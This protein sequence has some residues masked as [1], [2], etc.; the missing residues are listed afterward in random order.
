VDFD[1][2]VVQTLPPESVRERPRAELSIGATKRAVMVA[3][4]M[5]LLRTT[6]ARH[7]R[8]HPDGEHGRQ[9][10]FVPEAS[11]FAPTELA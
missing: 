6:A 8:I 7:V 1:D 3:Y 9:F 4:A 5:H 2:L 10:D 11:S